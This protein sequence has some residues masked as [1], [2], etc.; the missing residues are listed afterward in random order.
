LRPLLRRPKLP[1]VLPRLRRRKLLLK[2]RHLRQ[3][4][5]R[6]IN[7]RSIPLINQRPLRLRACLREHP[8]TRRRF[9]RERIEFTW[10][11]VILHRAVKSEPERR[12]TQ[13]ARLTLRRW[14]TRAR[15][16]LQRFRTKIV[17]SSS[18]AAQGRCTVRTVIW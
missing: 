17:G 3:P 12:S 10:M 16:P 6:Q 13:N 18:W 1:L 8:P 9:L 2:H 14:D 5:S 15:A 11:Q 4:S 7:P